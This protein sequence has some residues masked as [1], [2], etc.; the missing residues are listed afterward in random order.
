MEPPRPAPGVS[1]PIGNAHGKATDYASTGELSPHNGQPPEIPDHELLFLIGH[2]AYGEVW[3]ARNAV[4]TLRA[5]KIVHRLSFQHDDHFEREFKGLLKFEPISRSI[6]LQVADCR[7][8]NAPDS[9]VSAAF[10]FTPLRNRTRPRPCAG[11]MRFISFLAT[12]TPETG[13]DRFRRASIAP[14]LRGCRAVL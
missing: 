12:E 2:G 3:L 6:L 4:G 11:C 8:G 10:H 13:K 14:V 5:V 7:R 1:H 9:G